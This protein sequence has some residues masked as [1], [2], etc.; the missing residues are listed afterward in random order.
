MLLFEHIADLGVAGHHDAR[1][2][3]ILPGAPSAS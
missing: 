1:L 3:S 2:V